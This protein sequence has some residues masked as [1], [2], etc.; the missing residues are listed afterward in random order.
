MIFF[1]ARN[2][3]TK[4]ITVAGKDKDQQE[5]LDTAGCIYSEMIAAVKLINMSSPLISC[6]VLFVCNENTWNL[7][8]ACLRIQLL[9]IVIMLYMRSLDLLIL[10]SCNFVPFDQHTSPFQLPPTHDISCSSTFLDSTYRWDHVAFKKFSWS[11]HLFA[12]FIYMF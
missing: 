4:V 1:Y 9:A 3:K 7:L 11:F 12:Y 6:H 5:A 8:F 10:H 2:W